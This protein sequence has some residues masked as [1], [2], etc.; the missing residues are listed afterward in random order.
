MAKDEQLTVLRKGVDSWNI[1]RNENPRAVIDLSDIDFSDTN[2]SGIDFSGANL[3]RANLSRAN[4]RGANLGSTDPHRGLSDAQVRS[5]MFVNDAYADPVLSNLTKANFTGANL[6][7]ACL[8][9][10]ILNKANFQEVN[11]RNT[12]LRKMNGERFYGLQ[13]PGLPLSVMSLSGVNLSGS[14]LRGACLRSQIFSK[15]NLSGANLSRQNLSDINFSGANL[16]G[17]NLREAILSRTDLSGANLSGAILSRTDLNNMNLREVNFSSA[18]L[19][20]VNLTGVNLQGQNLSG[21]DLSGADLSG[22]DLSEA[23]LSWA[24]LCGADLRTA[25]LLAARFDRATLTDICLW[26]TQRTGWSIK[27]VICEAIYWDEARKERTLYSQGEFER[28]FS[29]KIKIVLYYENGISP[30][31]IVT[32]PAFIQRI[33]Q[34]NPGC[35]LRLQTI[36]EAP[37]GATVTFVIDETGDQTPAQLETDIQQAHIKLTHVLREND[38]LRTKLDYVTYE[39]IPSI[40]RQPM[41]EINIGGNVQ[42]NII[43]SLTGSNAQIGYTNNDLTG[44]FEALLNNTAAQQIA[45]V[46]D[47]LITIQSRLEELARQGKPTEVDSDLTNAM[48]TVRENS[49]TLFQQMIQMIQGIGSGIS[50]NIVTAVLQQQ[51]WIPGS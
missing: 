51:G 42:G 47:A 9:G 3:S 7:D 5:L 12:N 50:A 29:E 22:A 18:N 43:G 27:E 44:V 15:A 38:Q 41:A 40:V 36:E 31:E 13:I 6:E 2:L 25:R 33:E 35:I 32:L 26:E 11:F 4:L 39:L 16:S 34:E 19:R 49:P 20:E 46:H 8:Y 30:I 37:G 48:N 21:T 45:A 23:N 10:A 17:A 14:D 1:W 28:L 24:I